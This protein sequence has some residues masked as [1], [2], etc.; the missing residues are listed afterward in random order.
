MSICRGIF[1]A[2][3]TLVALNILFL[4]AS[5]QA[6]T[7]INTVQ[8]IITG[9]AVPLGN[10]IASSIPLALIGLGLSLVVLGV[11]YMFGEVLNYNEIRSFY[12]RELWETTKSALIIVI[13]FSALILASAIAVSFAGSAPA[14]SGNNAT[15]T[16]NL[17]SLYSTVNSSY[18]SPQL[19]NS[20][21]ALS[22]MF[23]LSVGSDFLKSASLRIWLPIPIPTEAGIIGDVEFG[24][25]SGLLQSNY[26]SA[27]YGQSFLD[28]VTSFSSSLITTASSL[29]LF[30]LLSFQIQRDL[31]YSIAALGLGVFIP[32]G[33]VM[34]AIPFIRGVGGSMI[35]L[36]IGLAIVYPV[37]LIGFNL[38][39]S[40][41]MYTLTAPGATSVS[42]CPFSYQLFCTV[43]WTPL[44]SIVGFVTGSTPVTLLFG[45]SSFSTAGITAA[46]S[47]FF[48]GLL[49]P[50]GLIPGTSSQGLF[51]ALN[52]VVDN[53]LNSIVQFLLF[54]LDIIIGVA[55]TQGIAGLM[56]GKIQLGIG[57]FKLA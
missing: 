15:I 49:G 24:A 23:G 50:F 26:I 7:N 17:A 46:N 36:G 43:L 8:C 14:A 9:T 3:L 13:I 2:L 52:F 39:V 10:C 53:S 11:A 4:N 38:P 22:G 5:A 45:T 54:I 25:Q 48:T 19:Q 30:V 55:I 57:Q 31:L 18:L 29:V 34:R 21:T 35:A 20:Y 32:I 51:P 16:A 6:S 27:L 40:N 44:V 37:L 42:A 12:K 28:Q 1:A 33:I 56:G 41:Y 47:G